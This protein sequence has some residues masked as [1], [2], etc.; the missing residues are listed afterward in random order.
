MSVLPGGW[1]LDDEDGQ[2]DL[3]SEWR[4]L[5]LAALA[6]RTRELG[7][8]MIARELGTT[9]GGSNAMEDYQ[10]TSSVRHDVLR[11]G[12]VEIDP[13]CRTV[14]CGFE[15]RTP[16][17]KVLDLIVYLIRH[18]DRVLTKE[19]IAREIW[20]QISVSEHSLRWLLKEAR[21]SLGDNGAEQRYVET[22]RGYGMRWVAEVSEVRCP[23]NTLTAACGALLPELPSAAVPPASPLCSSGIQLV[24]SCGVYATS[25]SARLEL[26]LRGL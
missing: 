24:G 1:C 4:Y 7:S 13:I 3:P 23:G 10:R 2:V 22:V 8:Y 11:S 21:R 16:P 12:A 17:R 20:P 25:S 5:A 9:E 6:E 19:E 14:R 18:R 26:E 15:L